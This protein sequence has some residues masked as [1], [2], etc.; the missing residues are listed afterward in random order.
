M[1]QDLLIQTITQQILNQN[2][3]RYNSKMKNI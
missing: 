3:L 2:L 1:N